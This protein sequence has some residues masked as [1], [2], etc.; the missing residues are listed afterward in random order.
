MHYFA[1]EMAHAVLSPWRFGIQAMRHALDW[2]MNP[3][4][5]SSMGRNISAACEVFENLT[6]RYGKPEFGIKS[7]KIEIGRAS[8]RERV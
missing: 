5:Q 3:L 7:V 2:P 6:R 4:G 8:C 1:Y